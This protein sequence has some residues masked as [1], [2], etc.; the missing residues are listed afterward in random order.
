MMGREQLKLAKGPNKV[1]MEVELNGAI[2]EKRIPRQGISCRT[3]VAAAVRAQTR[4]ENGPIVHE[5]S[6]L[7]VD[8]G[9]EFVNAL[10]KFP[11]KFENVL[12][13]LARKQVSEHLGQ[14]VIEQEPRVEELAG[15][16]GYAYT[17]ELKGDSGQTPSLLRVEVSSPQNA[18][19]WQTETVPN[20]SA[21]VTMIYLPPVS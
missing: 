14:G 1:A 6:T 4:L 19:Q 15:R 3:L 10:A 17:Y 12:K 21:T 5:R 18:Q 11:F 9:G 7:H 8:G 13:V 16:N 2:E 20:L